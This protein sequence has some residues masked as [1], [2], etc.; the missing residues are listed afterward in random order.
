MV[1]PAD[2][3]R[4]PERSNCSHTCGGFTPHFLVFPPRI[5]A[6]RGSRIAPAASPWFSPHR[7]ARD[8]SRLRAAARIMKF[9]EYKIV[10]EVNVE[11]FER[12]INEM[13]RAGWEPHGALIILPR[14]D[15]E[16]ADGLFQVMVKVQREAP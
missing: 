6:G 9:L 10:D 5:V 2:R 1:V 7:S 12:S 8:Q 4:V 14:H 13:I 11:R 15:N 3:H 16:I